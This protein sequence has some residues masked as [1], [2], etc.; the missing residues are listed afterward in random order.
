MGFMR[1]RR[2]AIASGTVLVV[3]AASLTAFALS[4]HG[5]PVQ[6]V[7]L[8]DGGVWVTNHS[9][10]YI[11]RINKPAG[12]LDAGFSPPGWQP[13]DQLD[14]R[15][16]G[17]AVVAWDQN[18][19]R[20]FPVDV[21]TGLVPPKNPGIALR[22]DTRLQ[23]GGGTLAAYDPTTGK[24]WASHV[25]TAAGLL[26][27]A[28][29]D[30]SSKPVATLPKAQAGSGA[31]ALSISD[32][33]V[34]YA[35]SGAGAVATVAPNVTGFAKPQYGHVAA[36]PSQQ[37][38]TVGDE[39]VV[40]DATD[41]KV[42]LPDGSPLA[43]PQDPAGKI[44]QPG[45]NADDV[46][47]ETSKELLSVPLDGGGRPSVL[48]SQGTGAPVAPVR[49]GG[50]EYAAWAGGGGLYAQACGGSP[51]ASQTLDGLALG[52]NPVFRVNRDEIVLNNVQ[53]GQVWDLTDGA[54][55]ANW[56]S[57]EPPPAKHQTK[58]KNRHQSTKASKA[59]PPKA[60]PDDLGV[61]AGQTAVL[62]VLDNDSH[63]SS[64]ILVID[65]I[66]G[67]S[68]SAVHLSVAPDEQ[69]VEAIIPSGLTGHVHFSYRVDDGGTETATAPVS[70]H[71]VPP[72]SNHAPKLRGGKFPEWTLPEGASRSIPVLSN[73]RDA[74]G[75]N[76]VLSAARA[77][78]GSVTTTVDGQLEYTAPQNRA[79]TEKL[80][81]QVTD[82]HATHPSTGTIRV[83]VQGPSAAPVRPQA[84]PDVAAGQ[85]NQPIIIHPF[86]NDI[87]GSVPTAPGTTMSLGGVVHSVPGLNVVTSPSGTITATAARPGSFHLTYSAAYGAAGSA[88][89]VIR[90]DA[91]S[92]SVA[93]S[94]VAMPDS[95][96]LHA[97]NPAI[98]DVL[99]NDYDPTGGVLV[100]Q[101]VSTP[102][103]GQLQAHV[104]AGRWLE[105]VAS[106][107]SLA[108]STQSLHYVISDGTSA[109]ADGE[110]TVTQVGETANDIPAPQA[111]Y[112][113]VRSGQSVTIPVLDNDTDPDGSPLS[114]VQGVRG[115]PNPGQLVVHLTSGVGGPRA[116]NAFIAGRVIKYVAPVVRTEQIATFDYVVQNSGPS[117][118]TGVGRVTVT[119][120][121]PPS[122]ANPDQA[123]RPQDLDI[124]MV[125]GTTAQITIPTA[126]TDP[127]GDT[128]TA[129]GLV[130]PPLL[131][132]VSN[133][134][135]SSLTY[136]AYPS[137]TGTDT[138]QY[139]VVD[140][141][142][143][144][145]QG[146]IRIGIVPSGDPQQPI[147]I[148]DSLIAAPGAHVNVDVLANDIYN[149]G[150]NVKI[151]GMSKGKLPSGVVS[152]PPARGPVQVVA[153][154]DGATLTFPYSISA[155]GD[156][157]SAQVTVTG[158]A[159][160]DIPPVAAD[161]FAK[162]TA[163]NRTVI[164]DV[165]S[166]ASDPDGP[167]SGL[168]VVPFNDP[169]AKATP[170]GSVTLPVLNAPQ[171]VAYELVDRGGAAASAVIHVPAAAAAGPQLKDGPIIHL[172]PGGSATVDVN[173][174]V[175]APKGKT[176]RL[177]SQAY[178]VPSPADG[179]KVASTKVRSLVI[180]A[181]PGYS[182]PAAVTF[183]VTDSATSYNE[184][185]TLV[186]VPVQIG[187]SPVTF[188]CPTG[189]IQ[190]APGGS[191]TK[192][193]PSIC[194]ATGGNPASGP[195]TYSA[196]W[197]KQP[198][199]LTLSSSGGSVT[200]TAAKTVA[201]SESGSIAVSLRGAQG[202]PKTVRVNVSAPPSLSVLPIDGKVKA[203]SSVSFNLGQGG[204]YVHNAL[205]NG[206]DLH[207]VG[208][209]TQT[210]GQHVP[211]PSVSGDRVTISPPKDVHGSLSFDFKISDVTGAQQAV[212]S[213][214]GRITVQV[215]GPPAVPTNLHTVGDQVS[216]Q[217]SLAWNPSAYGAPT[218]YKVFQSPG[219]P[220]SS[221]GPAAVASGLTNGQEYTFSVE[222]CNTTC[223][224]KSNAVKATP[225]AV[226][227]SP[228][229]LTVS[230]QGDGSLTLSWGAA[231]DP[232]KDPV[233]KYEITWGGQSKD[234]SG[235][236]ADITGLDN[237][238]VNTF[239][240]V[241]FNNKG[242]GPAATV[243][244]QSVGTPRWA[245]GA[246]TFSPAESASETPLV[247]VSWAAPDPNGPS[248]LK[249]TVTRS[250]Y[251]PDKTV[252]SD[253]QNTS[254]LDDGLTYDGRTYTYTV[255][256]TN[257]GG[258]YADSASSGFEAAI[259]PDAISFTAKA[260]GQDKQIA[261]TIDV[262]K[263]NG[264]SSTVTCTLNGSASCGTWGSLPV[265]G[266]NGL[267]ETITVP[268]N[269]TPETIALQDCNGSS[270][271]STACDA[272]VTQQET[273]YG[274]IPTPTIDNMS[275]VN[276]TNVTFRVQACGNGK[277]ATA[278]VTSTGGK[279]AGT[280]ATFDTT[281]GC[282]TNTY[283]DTNVGYNHTDKI[284]VVVSDPGRTSASNTAS[285]V[286]PAA[287][288]MSIQ[289]VTVNHSSTGSDVT[290]SAVVCTN[291]VAANFSVTTS[292]G[293]SHSGVLPGSGSC[294]TIGPW[295]D[296]NIGYSTTDTVTV[297]MTDPDSSDG[298]QSPISSSASTTTISAPVTASITAY[299]GANHTIA[300]E[301]TSAGCRWVGM[302]FHD[303]PT[304][305]YGVTCNFDDGS[306]AGPYSLTIS[307]PNQ[308]VS[309]GYCV[310]G[311]PYSA[312]VTVNGV[313]SNWVAGATS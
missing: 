169:Q 286:V 138:L 247:T 266:E 23:M 118:N 37:V 125:A 292:K 28:G 29:L 240:V 167:K 103:S 305:T 298:R 153:P 184:G 246:V 173:N 295:T 183:Q 294:A 136:L 64:A 33:G 312:S 131:G 84:K 114:L 61:R 129:A 74:D 83:R 204:G 215:S 239:S 170:S 258:K 16:D 302:Q 237:D 191:V 273:A 72:T 36:A 93:H 152:V 265:A 12:A 174:Y 5:N 209:V 8:N 189:P 271:A 134:G 277:A 306:H 7:D 148:P 115:A 222:A 201:Q 144:R 241:A 252:C 172:A 194:P 226:P 95:A 199:G 14:V 1:Q 171:A 270:Q 13:G 102:D 86:S 99:A 195:G 75:D 260:T 51:V 21:S 66:S 69:T 78:A 62:H 89:A 80:T 281:T 299:L 278:T 6:H 217:V 176:I 211:A 20:L 15:Q 242:P 24:V 280:S 192:Y 248:P 188:S 300:G 127:D 76:V 132:R 182:G 229:N 63:P 210:A 151:V 98:V 130:A 55:V 52:T 225:D 128:V 159:G 137:S 87:P 178:I 121:P 297:T 309:G 19:S 181:L 77:T 307:D 2:P 207:I 232:G 59:Q 90:V 54:Q 139:D 206:A 92:P 179:L 230:N 81:Y 4:S 275:V 106:T 157:T 193:L 105:I 269:G 141:F 223:S 18:A 267:T 166:Q 249:Y 165:L 291:G 67:L 233:S 41:G 50:C 261:L 109:A 198:K 96:V 71:V 142:G 149:P 145:T 213:A 251:G 162:P 88:R 216:G 163:G 117:E 43:V 82:G 22:P 100:V 262:P 276:G 158:R 256:A 236:S 126:G 140:S 238:T 283:T 274:P 147:A 11:G 227:G 264:L 212:R 58:K 94:P 123:P 42:T 285:Q 293:G 231:D 56:S 111:D 284:T 65:R 235:L 104:L 301:C 228:L 245:A 79:G 34:I 311:S 279:S 32:R 122:K 272:P 31:G 257:A 108:P 150:D 203:G 164:V 112:A 68:D 219:V 187:S 287:P 185:L 48:Y 39:R 296:S 190:V 27:I 220:F 85:I 290:Y 25:D 196:A 113:V 282:T 40:Y 202:G 205:N 133:I 124:R 17:S 73:W 91:A 9:D 303:F 38:T 44:Q 244:G 168:R 107:P 263:S 218:Y 110:V 116:G 46:L 120:T 197:T 186:T 310:V 221:T 154:A 224:A 175:T 49:L 243:Q 253:T 259:A 156:A 234:V 97:Q 47:I 289:S 160:Y 3:A 177:T 119:I 304:G 53:T 200:I 288:P 214:Q 45:P 10:G 268:E 180:R 101:S 255:R 26:A 155:G 135:T 143:E 57:V 35:V 308:N 60:R 313:T 254:C 70:L 146:A 161:V 30:S 208:S 250:G